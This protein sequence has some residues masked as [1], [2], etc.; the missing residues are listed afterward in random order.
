ML[1]LSAVA[2]EKKDKREDRQAITQ[3]L[4]R[5]RQGDSEAC[6]KVLDLLYPELHRLARYHMSRERP[7]HSLQPTALLNEAY[8]E[9]VDQEGQSWQN[10]AHFLAAAA[11]VMRRI[12][13][14]YAR[15]RLARKRGGDLV[16][17]EATGEVGV[18]MRHP[19]D[20]LALDRALDR[21]ALQDPELTRIVEM[22][23]FGGLTEEE[24][25]EALG[26]SSRTIKRRWKVAKA[27]LAAELAGTP[28]K[29]G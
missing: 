14:N 7:G 16:R 17:V 10:R 21:L 22:R 20:Y 12:L 8:V 1:R 29:T 2:S 28:Q 19:E 18:A 9:L 4:I 15:A 25:G 6:E 11:Q 3:W 23:Y 24:I 5:F 13:I 26:M 27:W